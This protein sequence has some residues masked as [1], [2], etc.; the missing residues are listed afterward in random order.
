MTDTITTLRTAAGAM[1]FDGHG[2]W[3]GAPE[4]DAVEAAC[5]YLGE[6]A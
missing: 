5:A 1:A 6:V 2:Y 3:L 4:R